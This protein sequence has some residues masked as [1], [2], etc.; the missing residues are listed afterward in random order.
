M[1]NPKK[2]TSRRMRGNRRSHHRVA[3]VK[4]VKCVNCGELVMPHRVCPSC[5]Y[6]KDRVVLA[7]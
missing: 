1:P 4:P 6:Y 5:G 3:M 7:S 2:K